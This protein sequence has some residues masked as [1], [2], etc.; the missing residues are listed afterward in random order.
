MSRFEKFA[1]AFLVMVAIVLWAV[2]GWS[3]YQDA[4]KAPLGP[5]LAL[6]SLQA[7]TLEPAATF[8]SPTRRAPV[9]NITPRPV[10]ATRTPYIEKFPLCGG[11]QVMSILAIGSDTRAQGYLYGLSDVTRLVRVDFVTPRVTVLEFPRDIWVEIPGIADHYGITHGKINQAYLYGNPGMGYYDGPGQGPGLLARTLELNFGA[12]PDHYIA[13]NMQTFVHLIDVIGGVD[14]TLPYSVDARKPDQQKRYDLYFSPG[15]HHLTGEQALMLARI[16]E[17]STFGRA[18]QQ[19]RVLCAARDALLNPS[20]LPQIPEIIDTFKKN[21]Q[22]DLSPE[23]ISQ[24]ACLVPKL[25]SGN[26]SFTTFPRELLTEARTYDIGVKKDVYIFKADFNVLRLYVS[27]FNSGNW[28]D[29]DP[30]AAPI[31]TPRPPG[32]GGFNCP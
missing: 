27:A 24:L 31:G 29:P 18:D 20:N 6:P 30:S 23:Q 5:E 10:R 4:W 28:P 22:T 26:I 15:T 13:A 16:R 3:T 12:H 25:K 2:V 1:L 11:P 9:F 7:P 21:I 8:S 14:V 19:N 17:H 32:E